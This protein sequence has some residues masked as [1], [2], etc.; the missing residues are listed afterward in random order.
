MVYF[1]SFLCIFRKDLLHPLKTCCIFVVLESEIP[2]QL[3]PQA[4]LFAKVF[5]RASYSPQ[6]I[7]LDVEKQKRTSRLPHKV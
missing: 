5:Q 4:K 1:N 7:L 2:R 6:Q 3:Q